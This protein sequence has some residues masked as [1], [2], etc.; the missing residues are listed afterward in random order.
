[1]D[2]DFRVVAGRQAPAPAPVPQPL[3]DLG[4]VEVDEV[5]GLVTV[6]AGTTIDPG[7]IGKGLAADLCVAAA[8]EAGAAGALVGIG[9]DVSAG[10]APPAGHGW[11]VSVPHPLPPA[12]ELL[13]LE[14]P[15][16]GIAT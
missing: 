10:G 13:R 1:Y 16:G 11:P 6:P 9:G 15:W 7:G 3:P 14:L 12:R 4:A 5:S 8:L 2:R